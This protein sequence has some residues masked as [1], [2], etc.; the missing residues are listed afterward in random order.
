M[1]LQ[2]E[3]R[4]DIVC[5]VLVTYQPD[6]VAVENIRALAAQVDRLC[7]V[8]NGSRPD[9]LEPVAAQCR[10]LPNVKLITNH[11]NLGIAAALNIGVT[12]AQRWGAHW[13]AT[14]DQ[15]SFPQ[16]DFIKGLLETAITSES[17]G[18]L[19]VI[20]P[21]HIDAESH[22]NLT[23]QGI[24]NSAGVRTVTTAMTSGN[25]AR[26]SVLALVGGYREEF[27]ID[28][29]D[30]EFCLRCRREGYEI[31]M[32]NSVPLAHQLGR[33]RRETLGPLKISVSHHNAL[34]RY[35]I[36]RNRVIL[37]REYLWAETPWVLR[38]M[39]DFGKELAK[40]LLFEAHKVN[41]TQMLVH[42]FWH[43]LRN[44]TGPYPGM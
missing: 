37:W 40:I 8:D 15:D 20:S 16:P 35:Y 1:N 7:V 4:S 29:V 5:G 39:V 10:A 9:A 42:G 6:S 2:S 31:L 43:A 24:R 36:T 21:L 18:R 28:Y 23:S 22:S 41:K 38:D 14:F 17:A 33:F 3:A 25:L 30:H 19:A 34:R 44:K 27:F 32:S 13:L 12:E 11:G 26:M